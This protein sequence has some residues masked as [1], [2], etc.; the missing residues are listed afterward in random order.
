MAGSP[1]VRRTRASPRTR[2]S[3]LTLARHRRMGAGLLLLVAGATHTLAPTAGG[4]ELEQAPS[5]LTPPLSLSLCHDHRTARISAAT[6]IPRPVV[7]KFDWGSIF[8]G[9]DGPNE[10]QPQTGEYPSRAQTAA[11]FYSDE[12]KRRRTSC[13]TLC[14]AVCLPKLVAAIEQVCDSAPEVVQVDTIELNIPPGNMDKPAL[15]LDISGRSLVYSVPLSRGEA[16]CMTTAMLRAELRRQL[17]LPTPDTELGVGG[18][19]TSLSG[20]F[21]HGV[22]QTTAKLGKLWGS[23]TKQ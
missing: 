12:Q 21:N 3:G 19:L 15:L 9:V 13:E 14:G 8:R 20:M 4:F 18:T 11:A 5:M 23:W 22:G 10:M 6:R 7:W 1:A 17:D 16:G 2:V